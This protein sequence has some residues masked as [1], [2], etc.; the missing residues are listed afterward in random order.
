MFSACDL[1]GHGYDS[2]AYMVG[3]I[4]FFASSFGCVGIW[5]IKGVKAMAKVSGLRLLGVGNNAKTIK[6]DGSEYLTA[7]LYL[8]PADKVEGIVF[9]L[10][11]SWQDARRVVLIV[12]AADR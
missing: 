5:A 11:L 12:Q 2:I 3:T 8:S 6:G 9:V 10:W 4:G 7:I 1:W